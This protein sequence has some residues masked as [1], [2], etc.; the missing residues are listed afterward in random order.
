MDIY[1]LLEKEEFNYE[2]IKEIRKYHLDTYNEGIVISNYQE[3]IN[4]IFL[5]VKLWPQKEKNNINYLFGGELAIELALQGNVLNRRKNNHCYPLKKHSEIVLYDVKE[6]ELGDTKGSANV[7][8]AFGNIEYYSGA[9][10]KS[11]SNLDKGLLDKGYDTVIINNE[12]ILIPELEILFL[13][14]Y[15][16]KELNPRK[17]GYDYEL[18]LMEYELDTDKI[19]NYLEEYYINPKINN[20]KKHYDQL[21]DKQIKAIERILNNGGKIVTNLENLELQIDSFPKGR[22]MNYAGISVDLWIPLSIKSISFKN[23][24]YHID[25]DKYVD[26][27]RQRIK[28]YS[29]TEYQRYEDIVVDIQNMARNKDKNNI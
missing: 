23:K 28:L 11:L 8:D 22:N 16:Q 17:E 24:Y 25:D 2:D 27:L 18:L 26:K 12:K 6:V 4:K 20:D 3:F 1:K 9:E 19:I 14:S 29:E 10:T 5:I 15:L 13:D 21:L 7:K